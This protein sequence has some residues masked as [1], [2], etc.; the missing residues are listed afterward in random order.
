[1]L[2]DLIDHTLWI[3]THEHLVPE[4]TRT[5]GQPYRFTD[6]V[7]GTTT[8][9]PVD[10]TYLIVDYAINDL[11]SSGLSAES[12]SELLHG[13][14][15]PTEKWDIVAPYFARARNTGFLRAVDVTTE[16]LF[17]HCLSTSSVESIDRA[18][19]DIRIA[20]YY[21]TLLAQAGIERCQV[22]TIDAAADPIAVPYE[23]N[24]IDLDLSLYPLVTGCHRRAEQLANIE[25]A[26]LT[27][28]LDV[29]D[30]CF[31]RDAARAI[32]VKCLWAY[33]RRIAA[34]AGRA[35]PRAEFRR[36]RHGLASEQDRR[37][38]GDYFFLHSL[39]RAAQFDLPVKIHVGYLAGNAQRQLP[40]LAQQITDAGVLAQQHP[41]NRFVLMHMGW[42]YQEH[43][44]ALA[45][46]LQNVVVD[47]C[48]S[49]ILA[50][51]STFDFVR[52]FLTTVPASKL[53]C[54]GGDYITIETVVG[55]SEL[56]RRGLEA[57]LASLLADGWLSIEAAVTAAV[58]L[59]RGNAEQVFGTR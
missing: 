54:F 39:A 30:A 22:H 11:V 53:L 5:N 33:D 2:R 31:E 9:V 58:M 7:D 35:S 13:S 3:D 43:M 52:R 42:P 1:V 14:R 46:H 10:W 16:V 36:L 37:L 40:G 23:S 51:A 24:L 12:A 19:R 21:D 6:A 26:E 47:L 45:K 28:Y 20:G 32:A 50:P 17:G 25:V 15:T 18:S 29:I 49:W 48:W 38:V 55:H 56:A 59:M 34:A 57:A 4:T 8:T 44:L 27:D 41:R